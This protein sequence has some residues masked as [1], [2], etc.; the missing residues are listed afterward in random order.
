MLSYRLADLSGPFFD[1]EKPFRNW[2]SFPYD[3][4]DLP[5]A[6]YVDLHQLDQGVAR[7]C[8]QLDVL[9]AQGYNGVVVDNLAHLVAFDGPGEP[10]YAA[11]SPVRRRALVY[12]RAFASL[13]EHAA[14]LG[15]HFFVTTDM[16]WSTP[17][18]RQAV[19]VLDAGNPRLVALNQRALAELFAALPQVSGLVVRVGEAGG[20]H[21]QG[22]TYTGHM[23]YTT[24]AALRM[25]IEQLLPVCEESGKQLIIR[26][27]SVGIGELG[28]LICSPAR[29]AATFGGLTSPNLLVSIKHG[30]AD[31]FR[32]LPANPTLGL[33]GPRQLIE[34]QNR[35]EYELFGLVPSS[36]VTL[37]GMALARA[38][39]DPQCAGFWAWNSTGGWGGG[40]ASLGQ[41]GWNLWTELNS[42]VT[43]A[44]ADQAAFASET[45]V[46]DWLHT[47]LGLVC[48]PA[49]VDVAADLYRDSAQFLEQGWY[50]SHLPQAVNRLGGVYLSPL[51]WVWWMRPTASLPIWAYLAGAVASPQTVLEAS[52]RAVARARKYAE[53]LAELATEAAEV[54]FVVDSARY[55]ADVLA[56]AYAIRAC[57]FA[58]LQQAQAVEPRLR[59]DLRKEVAQLME[60]IAMHQATWRQRRDFPALEL[61]EVERFLAELRTHPR[62]LELQARFALAAVGLIRHERKRALAG[63]AGLVGAT[64]VALVML[65]HRHGRLGLASLATGLALLAPLRHQAFQ[66]LLPWFSERFNVLP[67]IFFETGPALGEWVEG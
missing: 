8:A 48:S 51:L 49:F 44:L 11:D 36:I 28:D 32:L 67:S 7:A 56:L 13:A 45:F 4:L 53:R 16:Q 21:N 54:Q 1:P 57:M 35:R 10:V 50:M 25:L 47:R 63:A 52:A 59:S 27:W 24:S 29:Y 20:A 42:A 15:M 39:R 26:T 58:L 34:F 33:P 9:H 5:T 17:E 12:R 61:E 41:S 2:S 65:G 6:P 37:H 64:G 38:A 66:A 30:P 3:Q 23:I 18:L 14:A 31:F 43:A 19:G 60:Q 62:R 40:Q 55:L 22:D 46:R